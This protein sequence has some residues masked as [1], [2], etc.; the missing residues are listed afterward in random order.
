[1][2]EQ[3]GPPGKLIARLG[4]VRPAGRVALDDS[5]AVWVGRCVDH[6]C[7]IGGSS[8]VLSSVIT[9]L[10]TQV[11]PFY[12]LSESFR[13]QAPRLTQ[14]A[15]VVSCTDSRHAAQGKSSC[16]DIRHWQDDNVTLTYP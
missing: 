10:P 6:L 3:R 13:D 11:E 7:S 15:S 5:G 8:C 1:M 9:V 4:E 2:G 14:Q 12:S 16:I